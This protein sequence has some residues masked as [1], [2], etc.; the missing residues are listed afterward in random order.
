[1]FLCDDGHDTICYESNRCPL[2]TVIELKGKLEGKK[3]DLEAE[4][5]KLQEEVGDL[6]EE[7]HDLEGQIE[8]QG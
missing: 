5:E 4:I 7:V 6:K 1:M 8:E 3:E 2:C